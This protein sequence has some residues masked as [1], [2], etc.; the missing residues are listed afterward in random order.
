MTGTVL[1]VYEQNGET[2]IL[3][4]SLPASLSYMEGI[5]KY[6]VAYEELSMQLDAVQINTDWMRGFTQCGIED[7]ERLHN[8]KWLDPRQ[9]KGEGC[10]FQGDLR[11]RKRGDGIWRND[12]LDIGLADVDTPK[13]YCDFIY[14]L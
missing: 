13:K 5:E 10:M 8:E 2:Y 7:L 3:T 9:I 14:K 6:R 12:N 1:G 4:L 11:N